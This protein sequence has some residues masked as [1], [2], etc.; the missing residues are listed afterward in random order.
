M[1]FSL[2]V[3]DSGFRIQNSEFRIQNATANR[4]ADAKC[5]MQ[6]VKYKI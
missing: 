1:I 3:Q 4:N 6:N 5:K 2:K